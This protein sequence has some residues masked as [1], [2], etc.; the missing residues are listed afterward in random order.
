VKTITK[1]IFICFLI[2]LKVSLGASFGQNKV[3]G[4]C[5]D[6]ETQKPI[7]FATIYLKQANIFT[8]ADQNGYFEFNFNMFDT[9]FVTCIGYEPFKI[10][11]SDLLKAQA[12]LLK[13][14]PVQLSEIFIGNRKNISLGDL[15]G[16]KKFDMN[17][18]SCT[19]FE[20]ATKINIPDDVKE[21]QLKNININ[22]LRFNAENPVRIHIYSIGKYGEPFRELLKKDIIITEGYSKSGIISIS[23]EDQ[24]IV[25]S[26]K[27]FF[28]GIQ[29]IA[30]N[31]NKDR[32][33]TKKAD[34]AGPG[35]YCTYSNTNTVTFTRDLS[36]KRVGYKWMLYTKEV[37]YPFD[38]M[39]P[40]K[41]SYPLNMLV[42]CD[43]LY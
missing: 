21:Y 24:N 26:D 23:V 31:L 42:S 7:P 28:I 12:I 20:M 34:V 1:K 22:G 35:I 2:C 10:S 5:L 41:M 30:D 27:Y 13:P 8:D 39:L 32:I 6:I 18:E 9:V 36:N 11:T 4:T 16:K 25:L 40:E 37:L 29:W 14:L 19:R 38:Y 43:I 33:K 17:S 15:K 3:V